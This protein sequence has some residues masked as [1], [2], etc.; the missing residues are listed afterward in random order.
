MSYISLNVLLCVK[1]L[2]L[3]QRTE[4]ARGD[5]EVN[6]GHLDSVSGAL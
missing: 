1:N 5:N 3:Y 6:I 2:V 4:L